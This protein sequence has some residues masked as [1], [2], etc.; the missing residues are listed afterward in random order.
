[1]H[2]VQNWYNVRFDDYSTEHLSTTGDIFQLLFESKSRPM[3]Q[4]EPI[5]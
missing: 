2:E 5:Q 4:T 3:R 1:M